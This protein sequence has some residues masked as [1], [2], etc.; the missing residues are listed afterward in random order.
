[1][2]YQLTAEVDPPADTPA[3]DALQQH[4]VAALLDEHLDLLAEI[5]GPDGVEIEPV[6]HR[7]TVHPGG[8]SITW[9]LD[10][11][12]LAFA[13][14]A[15]R[16]VL[17]ELLERTELLS[18]WSVRRCE[19]TASDEELA[20]ALS[21]ID[22]AAD[23]EI[24]IDLDDLDAITELGN[25]SDTDGDERRE[26]LLDAAAEMAAFDPES[27]GFDESADES[28]EQ[29]VSED[30]TELLAGALMTGLDVLTEELFADVQTL[31]D[32]GI[33]ASEQEVLWVL[34]D[35]PTRYAG[36]YTALFAKKFLVT[37]AILGYRL[38]QPDWDG[39]RS[40]AEALAIRL[41]KGIA[42]NQL[43]LAGLVD[44]VPLTRM[45]EVFDEY[46]FAG[47]DVDPFF[48]ESDGVVD[49]DEDDVDELVLVEWFEPLETVDADDELEAEDAEV[50]E[51]MRA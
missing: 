1:M 32:T 27:F 6:D 31:E 9:V 34:H 50:D 39:P 11:P 51:A 12:A 25:V 3:L 14:E 24:E 8:A 46:A 40:I 28:D 35:L 5:E 4:G 47:I 22:D 48:A 44:D 43:D 23:V 26:R 29:Y 21:G 36:H 38:A 17:G 42:T 49:D 15:A 45:F 20:A 10:A 13:E 33:P 30:A 16:H 37:T 18:E 7:I 41:L 2:E 19:V